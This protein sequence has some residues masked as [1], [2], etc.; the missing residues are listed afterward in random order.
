MKCFYVKKGTDLK[1][2]GF[3]EKTYYGR[4]KFIIERRHYA[5]LWINKEDMRMTFNIP[6]NDDLHILCK[7]FKDN[8]IEVYEGPKIDYRK[9]IKGIEKE[10]R[11]MKEK[12]LFY[13]SNRSNK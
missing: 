10:L 1:K 11:E 7:M 6:T 5:R 4:T 9:K 13:E 3:V 8:V 2:Y 12:Q